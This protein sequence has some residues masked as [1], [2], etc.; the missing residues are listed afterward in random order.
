V[1]QNNKTAERPVAVAAGNV[2][3]EDGN[4][5]QQKQK[6]VCDAVGINEKRAGR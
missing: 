4:K 2:Y 5:Y 6:S 3:G 1:Q